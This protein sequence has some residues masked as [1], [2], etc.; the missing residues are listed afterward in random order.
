M[1]FNKAFLSLEQ[2]YLKSNHI[3]LCCYIMAYTVYFGEKGLEQHEC[4][5]KKNY[6][7][8]VLMF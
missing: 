8:I 3:T 5:L 2:I 4:K 7:C 1:A 6:F